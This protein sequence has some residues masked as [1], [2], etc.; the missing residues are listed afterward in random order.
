MRKTRKGVR[1]LGKIIS[2]VNQKGGVGKT[3]SCINLIAALGKLGKKC[4][5]VDIDSQGNS[6]S[7][8][9]INKREVKSSTYD[10]LINE[11]EAQKENECWYNDM[12][13]KGESHR[14]TSCGIGGGGSSNSAENGIA[15]YIAQK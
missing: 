14:N 11:E 7:G 3:T 15:Q 9:G 4:L 6:T 1:K 10:L 13:E 12:Y 2:I 8:L 5:L